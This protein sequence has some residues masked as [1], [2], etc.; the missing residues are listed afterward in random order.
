MINVIT[1]LVSLFAGPQPAHQTITI[2]DGSMATITAEQS[3]Y[4]SD[5]SNHFF[6]HYTLHNKTTQPLG[7]DLSAESRIF[8]P[9]QWGVY[10]TPQRM[11]I[12]ER[13]IIPTTKKRTLRKW[14]RKAWAADDLILIPPGE[15]LS[16]YKDFN[17]SDKKDLQ[18]NPGE[19]LIVS[20]DGEVF[21]FDRKHYELASKAG[22]T[23]ITA[24]DLA[25][26]FPITFIPIPPGSRV[27]LDE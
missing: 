17:A 5:I 3:L 23:S 18:G 21:F 4:E 10:P 11:I 25:L 27:F 8:H 22:Q 16:Y 26:P 9:N 1:L 14:L 12:D 15:S 7:V 19:Y 2:W 24:T 6:I 13:T 20:N